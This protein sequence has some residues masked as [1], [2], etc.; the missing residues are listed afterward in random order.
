MDEQKFM[1]EGWDLVGEKDEELERK[2]AFLTEA[3][4]KNETLEGLVTMSDVR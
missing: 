1:P 3:K 2:L 4:E